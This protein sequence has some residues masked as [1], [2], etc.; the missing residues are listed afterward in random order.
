MKYLCHIL[1]LG[2]LSYPAT[3]FANAMLYCPLL[4]GIWAGHYTDPTGL[5]P[6]QPFSIRL[7]LV[8]E[9]GHV[10]GYTLP[11][12]DRLG[13][14]YGSTS[15]IFTAVCQ[16]NTLSQIT[17]IQ[18]YHCGNATPTPA[19][20]SSV[21]KLIFHMHWENAMTGTDFAVTLQR[22]PKLMT[23][24]NQLKLNAARYTIHH[25]PQTCH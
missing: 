22:T 23:Q 11:S 13:E 12:D 6:N 15:H 14:R 24:I 20:L 25:P 18:P 17:V 16:N 8:Y 4:T 2:L 21:N 1:L 3:L 9:H 10:I 19:V 5:F 7:L